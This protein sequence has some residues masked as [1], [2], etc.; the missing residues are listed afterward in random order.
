MVSRSSVAAVDTSGFA[1]ERKQVTSLPLVLVRAG[2]QEGIHNRWFSG[3]SNPRGITPMTV[4]GLPLTS[5][6]RPRTFR[7]A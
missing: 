5:M 2:G 4:W 7:S 1:A 3:N 6:F